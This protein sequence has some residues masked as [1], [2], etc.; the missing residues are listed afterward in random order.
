MKVP[1]CEASWFLCESVQPFEPGPLHPPGSTLGSAGQKVERR[2]DA[3]PDAG[4]R[5]RE[6]AL[7]EEL[8]LGA[9]ECYKEKPRTAR[10][11]FVGH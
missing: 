6:I 11:Y 7:E 4:P 1:A 9:P 3:D 8:L 10:A 5:A 2:S